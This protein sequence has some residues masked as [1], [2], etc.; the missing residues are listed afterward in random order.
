MLTRMACG[1]VAVGDGHA[2][3][4]FH[5]RVAGT[6]H[7]GAD[8]LGVEQ[9]ADAFGGVERD[10][11]FVQAAG[12]MLPLSLPPCPASMTTVEK[13]F[14]A[15]VRGTVLQPARPSTAN[16]RPSTNR[17]GR[18]ERQIMTM[19][20]DADLAGTPPRR[21]SLSYTFGVSDTG[22]AGA[23]ARV[24]FVVF[25]GLL[26]QFGDQARSNRSGGSRRSRAPR[27]H[28]NTRGK[29]G[30]GSSADRSGISRKAR[31]PAV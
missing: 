12:R 19:E 20:K 15:I 11:L 17:S 31:T 23:L 6:R 2:V 16:G 1:A 26:E 27:R 13:A 10:F 29:T 30:T 25:A 14:G 4:E 21:Q 5:E 3:V 8:A 28:G 24:E 7:H 9:V 22:S 18:S